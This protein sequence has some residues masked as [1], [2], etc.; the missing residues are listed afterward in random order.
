L[1]EDGFFTTAFADL[2]PDEREAFY[3]SVFMSM[4]TP[5][6]ADLRAEYYRSRMRH[7]GE[8]ARIGCG[9]RIVNPQFI[10][11]GDNVCIGDGCVLIASSERGI[12]LADET[13]LC[14]GVYLDGCGEEGYIETGRGAY[15]GTRCTFHGHMGL[16]IGE[17]TLMAQ[18]ITITPYSHLFED[19]DKLIR[20]QGGHCRKVTIGRD[21][22]IGKSVSI[23]YS[24]DI[25]D[26]SV[27]GAGSLVVKSIPPYS[28]AFGHPARVIRKRGEPRTS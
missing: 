15:I 5:N 13:C 9:V 20:D 14:C 25:G 1:S 6:A 12:T 10:S 28:V 23:I 3:R 26:G 18:N 8:N 16:E 2:G 17:N 22:Y 4:D 24:A 7:M 11:L 19:P 27:V 21:C